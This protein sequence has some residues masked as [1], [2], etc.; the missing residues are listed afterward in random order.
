MHRDG[1][2]TRFLWILICSKDSHFP[3]VSIE[4][5]LGGPSDAECSRMVWLA[6]NGRVECSPRAQRLVDVGLSA[7]RYSVMVSDEESHNKLSILTAVC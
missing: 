6:R 2:R 3:S 7:Y 1:P 4:L 5:H